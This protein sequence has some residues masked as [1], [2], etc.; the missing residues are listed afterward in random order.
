MRR[1]RCCLIVLVFSLTSLVLAAD[2]NDKGWV[3]LT[4][5]QSLEAFKPPYTDWVWAESVSLDEKNPRRFTF[6]EG[7][8]FIV[9]GEKGRARNLVTKESYQ[10]VEAHLEFCVPKGSNSGIKFIE[11]YEIQILDSF[12]KPK[13]KLT[14]SDC[15]GVY[16]RGENQPR[17]HTI[18]EGTPP[19]VNACKAPGEWQTL[20]IVFRAPRFD[21]EGKK[22][23][24]ARF[25]KVTLND[26]VIHEN[27]ELKYPTGAAWRLV[28]EI[29]TGPVMLQADH[30]P[31]AFRNVRVRPVK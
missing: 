3:D 15:G 14:G 17:Y 31:V 8:A 6:K 30:G 29:P 13:E 11:R 18:D 23:E 7:K 28:K 2:E 16:P 20:D 26:Q 10:D 24:N 5:N 22:I 4:A 27:V 25:V 19:R 9:N 21:K 1:T 12:G